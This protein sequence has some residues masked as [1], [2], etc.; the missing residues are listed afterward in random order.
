MPYLALKYKHIASENFQIGFM[1]NT[2]LS[3]EKNDGY[4]SERV[5]R[6]HLGR[7]TRTSMRRNL[8]LMSESGELY[9][10]RDHG[11]IYL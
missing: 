1:L 8:K 7:E 9:L 10:S 3:T 11:K 5:T 4:L 6:T 2:P